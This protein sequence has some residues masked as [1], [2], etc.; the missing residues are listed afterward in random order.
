MSTRV[1]QIAMYSSVNGVGRLFGGRLME[2]VDIA[3]AVEAR[4]HAL[5]D[6]TLAAVDSLEFMEPVLLNETV[7]LDAEVTWTGRTSIEVR[8]D[9]YVEKLDGERHQVNR[10]YL[11]YVAVD[12]EGHPKP[13][14][15]F[16][17]AD[18]GQRA[19][20]A[21]ACRRNEA[22]RA[23]RAAHAARPENL[24]EGEET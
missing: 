21:A 9:S 17:P 3:G 7:A 23:R 13:V 10:A 19:E 6:V 1:V 15:P 8:V 22:R 18:A 20:W 12:D 4:R 11:I 24:S 5:S 16:E 14:R 2:W